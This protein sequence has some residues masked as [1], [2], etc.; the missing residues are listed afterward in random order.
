VRR[1]GRRQIICNEGTQEGLNRPEGQNNRAHKNRA[2][3]PGLGAPIPLSGHTLLCIPDGR[4]T[5]SH[6]RIRQG[7]RTVHAPVQT[8]AL[9]RGGCAHLH[10]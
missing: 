7:R 2:S 10:R 8:R 5:P 9:Q 1:K 3:G 4:Q 6:S